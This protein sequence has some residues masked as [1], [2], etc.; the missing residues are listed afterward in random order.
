MLHLNRLCDIWA[1]YIDI[2][3]ENTI[4]K[5]PAMLDNWSDL[6]E[7]WNTSSTY[8]T[9]KC[10]KKMCDDVTKKMADHIG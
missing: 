1:A 5:N 9:K 7:N 4:E 2:W 6:S 3:A 10:N 8:K